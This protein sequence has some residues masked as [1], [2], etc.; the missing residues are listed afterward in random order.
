ML[1]MSSFAQVIDAFRQAPSTVEMGTK[2]EQLMVRYFELD[3]TLSREYD[4]VWRWMDWPGRDGKAD[5][6]IDLVA[7]VRDTHEYAAI[8]CKFYAPDHHLSKANIDSFLAESGKAPFTR[9]IIIST[10]NKWGKN[11]LAALEGLQV[12]V[13]RIGTEHLEAAPIDWDIAWPKGE[14]SIDLSPSTPHA[15]RPHQQTAVDKV[16]TG[17]PRRYARPDA[18][19][20]GQKFKPPSGVTTLTGSHFPNISV[21]FS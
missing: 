15:L 7:R 2:F 5:M 8:Q 13:Q 11:A 4:A 14:L 12:S 19:D 10:T 17:L 3:P 6:G 21:V 1:A 18:I 9:R 20:A 16:F